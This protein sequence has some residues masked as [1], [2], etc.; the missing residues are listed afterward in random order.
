MNPLQLG[1]QKAELS[2]KLESHLKAA[3][4]DRIAQGLPHR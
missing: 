3:I 4:A 1:R 2:E